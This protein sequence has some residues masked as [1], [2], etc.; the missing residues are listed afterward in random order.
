MVIPNTG[1]GKRA[2]SIELPPWII[3]RLA[4]WDLGRFLSANCRRLADLL[5]IGSPTKARTWD[6]RINRLSQ[7]F[8]FSNTYTKIG[9]AITAN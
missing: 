1:N 8:A 7:I 9:S 3:G 6:M 4:T 5:N 2:G